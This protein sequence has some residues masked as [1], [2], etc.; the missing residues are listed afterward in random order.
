MDEAAREA[1]LA[2]FREELRANEFARSS[3]QE[4]RV[5]LSGIA[6]DLKSPLATIRLS[7][8]V[9]EQ[10]LP[11][12]GEEEREMLGYIRQSS[13]QL[14]AMLDS[15]LTVFR[16]SLG[17]LRPKLE[18]IDVMPV[19]DDAGAAVGELYKK[20]GI[21]LNFIGD[22]DAEVTADAEQLRLVLVELLENAAEHAPEH[23]P[24]TCPGHAGGEGAGDAGGGHG[25]ARG[26]G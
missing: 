12:L 14:Q 1:R 7:S 13:D 17:M 21:K 10:T 16:L 9:L 5:S 8:S 26:G 15:T 3:S 22:L 25:R 20:R 18:R 6:H 11:D 19:L 23:H 2:A 4:R 24:G